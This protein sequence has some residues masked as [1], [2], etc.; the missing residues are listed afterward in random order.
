MTTERYTKFVLTTIAIGLFLIAF[1]LYFFSTA[2]VHASM[3]SCGKVPSQPC[4]V[5]GWGPEG[6]VPIANTGNMPL[7]VLVG[8]PPNPIPVVVVNAPSPLGR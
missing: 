5:A 2:V 4:Y 7:K 8:N 6:T 1:H 3:G